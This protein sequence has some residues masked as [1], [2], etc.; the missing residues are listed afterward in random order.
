M[1]SGGSAYQSNDQYGQHII[2]DQQ[3]FTFLNEHQNLN[4]QMVLAEHEQ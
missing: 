4:N 1:L 3:A 2:R